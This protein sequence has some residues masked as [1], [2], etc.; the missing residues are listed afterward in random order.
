MLNMHWLTLHIPL[1]SH[2]ITQPRGTM[3][4]GDTT[5]SKEE[6]KAVENFSTSEGRHLTSMEKCYID[7]PKKE[8]WIQSILRIH[9]RSMLPQSKVTKI[10]SN[11]K[12]LE[13]SM[14][15]SLIMAITLLLQKPLW[16]SQNTRITSWTS[17]DQTRWG[18]RSSKKDQADWK[19]IASRMIQSIDTR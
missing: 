15:A 19:V 6:T 5:R 12:A 18:Q 17:R 8:T 14:W 4:S 7:Y 10:S 16:A 2:Y 3:I 11:H 1:L 9:L 13:A